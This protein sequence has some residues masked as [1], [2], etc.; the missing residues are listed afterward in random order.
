MKQKVTKIIAQNEE[1][2][3]GVDVSDKKHHLAVSD[4]R[5]N[6]L[7]LLVFNTPTNQ[8]WGKFLATNFSGCRITVVYESGPQ[9]YTLYDVIEHLGHEGVVIKPQKGPDPIKTNSRDSQTIVK[10]YLAKRTRKVVVPSPEKRAERQA[11]RTRDA[12]RKE[13]TQI[14][15]RLNGMWRFH[16]LSGSMTPIH[17]DT[18]GHVEACI[19]KLNEVLS[20]LWEQLK[21]CERELKEICRK[22]KYLKDVEKLLAIPGVG[23]YTAM[24]I[25]LNAPGMENFPDSDHFASFLGL[26]PGEWSTGEVRRL[27]RITRRGPG[28]VR[29]ALVQ[30]AWSSIRCDAQEREFYEKLRARRGKK[31]AIVAVARRLAVRIWRALTGY[32]PAGAEQ[33]AA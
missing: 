4:M 2:V 29:G 22:E 14:K 33:Q 20:F 26:T 21:A 19:E 13:I 10:D 31:K 24:Q 6:I 12:L 25:M 27:G 30:C 15:N 5:G 32:E 28:A 17:K 9:G 3:I 8:D 7:R 23:P 16:G 11:L 18:S 1:I